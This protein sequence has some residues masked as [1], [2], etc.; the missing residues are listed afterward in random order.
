MASVRNR[1]RD[2]NHTTL[3]TEA[4]AAT[5]SWA[6]SFVSEITE[7]EK[8][9]CSNAGE[10]RHEQ[11]RCVI[12]MSQGK[13]LTIGQRNF[14]TWNAAIRFVENLL[15]SQQ[16][17]V[18]IQEPYHSFLSALISRHPHFKEKVGKG[19][20]HFTVENHVR[21]R[22][23]LCLTRIDGTKTDFSFFE[24]VRARE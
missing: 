7:A 12:C 22:R 9:R 23:C 4:Q 1:V 19:I 15:Y 13:R 2:S 24:C 8:L 6:C 5:P 10:V 21:G 20:D 17:K 11:S 14:E 18:P 16:L 3:R